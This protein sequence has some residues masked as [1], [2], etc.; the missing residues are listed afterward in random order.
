M[1]LHQVTTRSRTQTT[2]KGLPFGRAG[3]KAT[4]KE[5]VKIVKASAS[6]ITIRELA[7]S[8]VENVPAKCWQCEAIAIMNFVRNN[9]RYTRDIHGIETIA[10]PE[11]TLRYRQGDCDD[12]VVLAASLLQAIG[13]PT[14]F[15]AVGF[16]NKPISH[17]YLETKIGNTWASMELTEMLPF[18]EKPAGISTTLLWH[19]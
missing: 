4:L 6:N 3:I 8:I 7:F 15:V 16:H 12:M 2:L 19:I 18:N 11:A 9:I 13:H 17:V 5:M 10:T 14:R 1:H